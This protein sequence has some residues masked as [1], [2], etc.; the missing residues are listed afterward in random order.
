MQP[1]GAKYNDIN[2]IKHSFSLVFYLN[3]AKHTFKLYRCNK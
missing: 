3:G 2:I 1:G